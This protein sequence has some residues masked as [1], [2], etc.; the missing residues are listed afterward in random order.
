MHPVSVTMVTTYTLQPINMLYKA[1]MLSTVFG[2]CGS[3][4]LSNIQIRGCR[5][6]VVMTTHRV[7]AFLN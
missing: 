2:L 3:D 7:W 1:E 4:T 5:G 6:V